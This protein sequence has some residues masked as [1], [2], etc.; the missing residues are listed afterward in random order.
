MATRGRKSA[1]SLSVITPG[2]LEAIRRPDP[3]TELTVEQAH[4]WRSIT[5]RMPADWFPRETH[6]ML[7]QYCRHLVAARRIAQ[8]I[9][10]EEVGDFDLDRYDQLLKMQEREGRALSS[11][12]TRMRLTQQSTYS[13]KKGKGPV[14][15]GVKK[16]WEFQG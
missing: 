6:G 2:G 7:A 5:N 11:L 1:A 15:G 4:E 8:L 3:P 14:G 13:D 16:P 10:A 9:D 12:A